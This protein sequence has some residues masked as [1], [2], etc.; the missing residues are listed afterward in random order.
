MPLSSLG[1][2]GVPEHDAG[3]ASATLNATQQVGGSLGVAL[4]STFATTAMTN[5]VTSHAPGPMIQ[6]DAMIHSYHVVFAGAPDS[7]CWVP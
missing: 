3:A 5:W 7:S 2:V 1:A 6:V 4:L